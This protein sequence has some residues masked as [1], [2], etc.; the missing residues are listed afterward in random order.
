MHGAGRDGH[1]EARTCGRTGVCHSVL[2][3]LGDGLRAIGDR[4]AG[5]ETVLAGYE[6]EADHDD[7]EDGWWR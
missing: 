1:C 3:G 6:A 5:R 7:E 2:A 4:G